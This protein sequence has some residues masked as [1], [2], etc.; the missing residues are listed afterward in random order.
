MQ[1][2]SASTAPRG[3]EAP[4]YAV[5][6]FDGLNLMVRQAE[7][8][9]LEPASAVDWPQAEETNLVGRIDMETGR[10]PVFC[11]AAGL[12][13]LASV[14]PNRRV[15]ILLSDGKRG[16]GLLCDQVKTVEAGRLNIVPM[17]ACMKSSA[18]PLVGMALDGGDLT[19]LIT[20]SRLAR[21]LQDAESG[22][23]EDMGTRTLQRV[24]L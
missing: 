12:T 19:C 15:C 13:P 11:L 3:S 6:T 20:T 7:V 14:P 16:F 10:W 4:L 23:P 9:T 22:R 21:F 18:S 1:R 8:R 2:T 24:A 17:P 5:L